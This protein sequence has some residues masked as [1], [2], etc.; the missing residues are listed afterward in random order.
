MAKPTPVLV[1]DELAKDYGDG[2]GLDGLDLEVRPGEVVMLVG[3]NGAGKSTLLTM[4]AGLLES[5]GGA[6]T[7]AGAEVGTTAARAATS[8]LPDSPVLYDDLSVREQLAYVAA[9]HGVAVEE[10]D[11]DD[12]LEGLDD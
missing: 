1:T 2:H 6:I 9:L 10:S 11:L 7:V 8:Y 12:L 3:P 5:S 4:V